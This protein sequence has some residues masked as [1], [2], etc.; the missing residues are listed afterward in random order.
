MVKDRDNLQ[1]ATRCLVLGLSAM[2]TE[3]EQE[4]EE[5]D[6]DKLF[7]SDFPSYGQGGWMR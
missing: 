1:D 5:E 6:E 2:I 3:P 4:K 7:S